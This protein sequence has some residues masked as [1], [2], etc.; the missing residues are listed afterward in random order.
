MS[1]TK[2]PPDLLSH[3][4]EDSTATCRPRAL[5]GADLKPIRGGVHELTDR[6]AGEST[7]RDSPWLSGLGCDGVRVLGPDT[8]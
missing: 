2:M 4:I 1:L 8:R 6:I 5:G 3:F 7:E